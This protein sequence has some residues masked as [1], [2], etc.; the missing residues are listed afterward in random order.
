MRYR[1]LVLLLAVTASACSSSEQGSPSTPESSMVEVTVP[2]PT[3]TS[4]ETT[5]PPL[6]TVPS[7]NPEPG[8]IEIVPQTLSEEC[9]EAVADLRT[10]MEEYPSVL[11]VPYDGTYDQAFA[12]GQAGCPEEEFRRFH[13]LELLGW[14]YAR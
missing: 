2:A 7:T 11:D 12:K 1:V 10:L 4:V 9:T 14:I 13:D 3:E 6:V 5:L 8:S